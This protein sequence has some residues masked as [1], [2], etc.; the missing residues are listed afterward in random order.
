MLIEPFYLH[1]TKG[2]QVDDL[3]VIKQTDPRMWKQVLHAFFMLKPPMIT[4]KLQVVAVV[5]HE[6]LLVKR[7]K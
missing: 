7:I 3:L 5:D 1:S 4:R 6:K 2:I